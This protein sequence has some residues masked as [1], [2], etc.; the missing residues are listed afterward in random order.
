M[1]IIRSNLEGDNC[2]QA[3]QNLVR[4]K[5]K[6]PCNENAVWYRNEYQQD[7]LP[8]SLS[9]GARAFIKDVYVI[10]DAPCFGATYC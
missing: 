3:Q 1:H 7:H 9:H 4:V 2:D 8:P 10:K 5:R 6:S